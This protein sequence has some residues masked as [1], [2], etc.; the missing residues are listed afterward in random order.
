M[1]NQAFQRKNM[2]NYKNTVENQGND[3][4]VNEKSRFSTK[5]HENNY[6]NNRK[7]KKL[8]VFP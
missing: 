5:K 4:F 1:N 6:K 2:K 8:L 3:Q 7:S